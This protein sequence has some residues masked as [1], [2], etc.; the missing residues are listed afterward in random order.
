[1]KNVGGNTMIGTEIAALSLKRRIQP[2]M[3]RAH[4]MWLYTG[5]KVQG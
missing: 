4:Q 5:T 1:M 2:V 3:S